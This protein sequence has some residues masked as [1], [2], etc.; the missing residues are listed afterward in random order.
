MG[1]LF[2]AQL[3]ILVWTVEPRTDMPDSIYFNL[4]K[5]SEF[6]VLGFL[7]PTSP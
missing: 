6:V 2:P 4:T 7:R 1:V 5:M 3:V